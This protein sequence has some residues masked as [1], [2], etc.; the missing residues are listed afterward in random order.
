LVVVGEELTVVWIELAVEL[1]AG[2]DAVE[3]VQ[4]CAFIVTAAV[5]VRQF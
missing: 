4:P 1:A 2:N 3:E 5:S